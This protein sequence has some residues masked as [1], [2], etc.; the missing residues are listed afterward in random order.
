[1]PK[2]SHPDPEYE[3]YRR[4]YPTFPGVQTCLDL[5]QRRNVTGGYWDAVYTDLVKHA[6][7]VVLEL[8][9]AG[10]DDANTNVRWVILEILGRVQA[11]E[12]LSLFN[13]YVTADNESIREWAARGLAA[14][15][16]KVARRKLWEVRNA[17]QNNPSPNC[18]SRFTHL[19]DQLLTK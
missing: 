8:I 4:N 16:T 18:D 15:D 1:M 2:Y 17:I 7:Q 10:R 14:L 19:L 11:T 9:Q 13:D 6:P 12:A 5:L 3:R